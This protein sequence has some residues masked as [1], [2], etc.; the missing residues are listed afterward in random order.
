M[1]DTA[2]LVAN[3]VDGLEVVRMDAQ[4]FGAGMRGD[5]DEVVRGEAVVDGDQHRTDLRH[6]IE[7]FE[8][9]VHVRRDVGDAVTLP[10]PHRLQRGRPAV[11]AVEELLVSEA[12]VA[13]DHAF[14]IAVKLSR[15][16]RELQRCE[17]RFHLPSL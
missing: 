12:E 9:L 14:A 2:Q 3:S 16:P 5:V 17:R 8:L 13:V 10:N 1:F 6:G 7:G 11:A 4:D 15:P